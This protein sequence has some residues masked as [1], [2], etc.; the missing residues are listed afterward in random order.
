MSRR[1]INDVDGKF[2][3]PL[4][5]DDDKNVAYLLWGDPVRTAQ[6]SGQ[7]VRVKARGEEGWVPKSVLTD[8]GLLEVYVI[9][10]GQGD[11]VL[12][13]TP[14]DAWHL[15]DAGVA[16]EKQMTKKGAANFIRWKFL[17]DLGR[18]AVSLKN[19]ILS[20][21]DFDHYGGML[22]L[23]A[24]KVMR[25]DRTFPVK[26][27]TLYHS[28]V[29]RFASGAKLGKTVHGSVVAL[30]YDDYGIST[31]DDFI[32]ELL[33]GK[34]SFANPSRPFEASFAR[35]ADLVATVPDKVRRLS[36]TDK[37]LPGYEPDA[38]AVSIRILG[39]IIE[40]VIG[41]GRGLRVFGSESVTRNG[42]SCVLRVDYNKVRIL[43][44]GDLNTASQRL[45]LSYHDLLEFAADVAKGCHHGSDDIDLRFVR[46]M[47]ARATIVSSGDNEDYAHP[48]PRVLGAS[49]RYGRE[50]KSVIGETLPPLLYSTELAR[51][52]SLSYSA[53][54]R[55]RGDDGSQ[56]K[57]ADTEIKA[58]ERGATFVPLDEI[59]IA[60]D[61]IYG[62]INVRTDGERVMCAYMKENTKDFDVKVFRGGVEP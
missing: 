36:H 58:A 19:L 6:T 16:N 43:L 55:E 26:V 10:V 57:A 50:A 30:P 35:F 60:M 20:H 54:V 33:G 24:G 44:T 49:A 40:E 47:K 4:K 25:P 29:G 14:D 38:G 31:E 28:G 32:T 39:P 53:A 27:E 34:N 23:L 22:D 7:W 56:I 11:G 62:L 42:H 3:I 13:R 2:K 12:I 52:V 18:E 5:D 1:Y 9:D 21:P 48:R 59:P 51:S 46:A 15:I 45:L 37:Y 41:K 17:D 61:L 8:E